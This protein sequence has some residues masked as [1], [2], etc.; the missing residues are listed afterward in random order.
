M[1]F[2]K[3][4]RFLSLFAVFLFLFSCSPAPAVENG[5]SLDNPDGRIASA[6]LCVMT[7]A[8][9]PVRVQNPGES[10]WHNGE[11]GMALGLADR[12]K[13]EIG[14]LASLTFFDGSIIEMAEATEVALKELAASGQSNKIKLQQEIGSTFNRVKKLADPASC[15]EIETRAAVAG[16]RGTEFWVHVLPDGTT[17]V[18]NISGLVCVLAQGV[19]IILQP[20]MQSTITPG[21]P[22]GQPVPVVDTSISPAPVTTPPSSPANPAD[23]RAAGISIAASVN[24]LEAF[25]GDTLVFSASVG[26]T[27]DLPL[28]INVNNR[29]TD[30]AYIQGD[31]DGNNLLD[32]TETWSYRGQYFVNATD[33]GQLSCSFNASGTGDGNRNAADAAVVSIAIR[34]IVVE[35]TSLQES[36]TVTR[37]ITVAGTVNDPSISQATVTLNGNPISVPVVNGSFTTVVSLANGVNVIIVTV[38]KPGGISASDTVELE[39]AP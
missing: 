11:V 2:W 36:Q 3:F 31:V 22:P 12:V 9:G 21:E 24:R 27:G 28:S 19:E 1:R 38:N 23:T 10:A 4:I 35:V 37:E 30:M 25:P 26:N 18:A 15:Y 32:T 29:L 34:D 16:V 5:H 6:P 17:I 7:A 14:G 20:G 13:T 8:S 39:P 33:V